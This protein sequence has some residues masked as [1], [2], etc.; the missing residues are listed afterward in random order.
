M[1]ELG[2]KE[3]RNGRT[4]SCGCDKVAFSTSV[5]KH[6]LTVFESLSWFNTVS[7]AMV[8]IGIELG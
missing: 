5:I 7:I 1:G 4:P 3:L 6:T 8:A 2:K